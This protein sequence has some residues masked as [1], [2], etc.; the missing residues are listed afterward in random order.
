MQ[1][2]HPDV[3][4]E[5]L[6]HHLINT[7]VKE[8]TS[9]IGKKEVKRQCTPFKLT[10]YVRVLNSLDSQVQTISNLKQMIIEEERNLNFGTIHK[11]TLVAILDDLSL[12]KLITVEDEYVYPTWR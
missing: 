2:L 9:S 11:R 1:Q 8:Y 4:A 12:L 3:D 6:L 7:N 5:N 10:R